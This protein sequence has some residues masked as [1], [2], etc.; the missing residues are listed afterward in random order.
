MARVLIRDEER[1]VRTDLSSWLRERGHEVEEFATGSE[2]LRRMEEEDFDLILCDFLVQ[3]EPVGL[4]ILGWVK[5]RDGTTEVIV[6]TRQGNV[7]N[8]ANGPG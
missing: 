7:E 6:L 1:T 2:A 4:D 5:G 3:E 8:A